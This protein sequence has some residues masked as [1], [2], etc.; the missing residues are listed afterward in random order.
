MRYLT[1]TVE[2][3]Q[4]DKQSETIE[5]VLRKQW[6]FTKRQIRQAKFRSD[7]ILKNGRRCRVTESVRP[8]DTIRICLEEEREVSGHLKGNPVPLEILYEDEDLLAVNKPA[9]L[10]THPRGGH[11]QDTLANQAASY[12]QSKGEMHGVRPIGRLDQETSGVVVFAKSRMAAA[13]LQKQREQGIYQKTYLAVVQGEMETDGRIRSVRQ[14]IGPDSTNHLKMQVRE[15]GKGAVTHYKAVRRILGRSVLE[16]T[17]ET[18]RTHQIRVHMASL[19][20]PL[21]GDRL[22]GEDKEGAERALLH[23]WRVELFQP[24]TGEAIRLLA[25]IPEDMKDL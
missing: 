19:G 10:V 18:G 1:I 11:Y 20:H 9:G 16:V 13:R 8:G 25:P 2:K 14:P 22:Y 7:G 6:G 15:D 24:F 17:L 5:Q 12:F 23:A 21:V 4:Q 3:N